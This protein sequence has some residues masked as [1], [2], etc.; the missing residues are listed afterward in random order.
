VSPV[1]LAQAQLDAYN[2]HDLEAFLAC[3][4]EAVEV[5]DFP[6]NE[7]RIA[8]RAAMRER[9]GPLLERPGLHAE[10]VDRIALGAVVIDQES[11]HGLR[12]GDVVSAVAVYEV[13]DELIR[14]VWF[15]REP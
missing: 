3:Y 2:A 1:D 9:Y 12:E 10:L 13:A 6:S 5:R 15:I 8:G 11:V 7:L 14:R 4:A